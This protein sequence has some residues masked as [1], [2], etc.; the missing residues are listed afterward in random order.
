[1]RVAALKLTKCCGDVAVKIVVYRTFRVVCKY[2]KLANGSYLESDLFIF[3]GYL[4]VVDI[5]KPD[6]LQTLQ[7]QFERRSKHALSWL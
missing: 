4:R 3:T 5:L 2:T 6:E 7:W 1:M